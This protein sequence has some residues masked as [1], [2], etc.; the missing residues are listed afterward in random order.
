MQPQLKQKD[1]EGFSLDMFGFELIIKDALYLTL[2]VMELQINRKEERA[3]TFFCGTA[4]VEEKYLKRLVAATAEK[5]TGSI[6]IVIILFIQNL[7]VV[8][9]KKSV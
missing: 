2:Y 9:Q 6:Q 8:T 3:K 7:F 4:K 1:I 5:R